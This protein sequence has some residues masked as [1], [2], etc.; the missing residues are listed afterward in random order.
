MIGLSI[1]S[2]LAR[3]TL[4]EGDKGNPLNAPFGKAL[5][6]AVIALHSEAG[7]RAVL[8][9]S[10]GKHFCF[11]GDLMAME[12]ATDLPAYVRQVTSDY[13]YALSLLMRLRAPIICAVQ[14]ASAGA[15]VALGALGD[16]VIA[17]DDAHFTMAYTGIA[18]SP[19]GGS[20]FLLPRLIGLRRFQELVLTNRRVLAAEAKAIGLVTEIAPA[21]SFDA[22]VEAVTAQIAAGPTGAYGIMRALLL[23]APVNALESQLELEARLLSAQSQSADVH[24]GVAAIRAKRPP[25]FQGV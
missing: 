14:G 21:A 24:E 4:T 17:R 20:T 5:R 10:R 25:I 1:E 12:R 15:G 9:S 22:C 6:D 13:H 8:L 23:E 11:G 18:F 16:Y 7:L 19:D 2:G 3:L